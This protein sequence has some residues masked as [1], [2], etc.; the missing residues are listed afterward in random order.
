MNLSSRS[1]SSHLLLIHSYSNGGVDGCEVLRVITSA[2]SAGSD[3]D[4]SSSCHSWTG[5][6]A[7]E[8]RLSHD[9]FG[10]IY[11][12]SRYVVVIAHHDGTLSG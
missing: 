4:P 2:M 12:R 11:P 10:L 6:R 7:K 1:V 8:M 9:S 3:L 5:R